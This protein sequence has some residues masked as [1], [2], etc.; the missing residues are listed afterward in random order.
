MRFFSQNDLE[1]IALQNKLQREAYAFIV[2][3][4]ENHRCYLQFELPFH[5]KKGTMYAGSMMV[6]WSF[7]KSLVYTIYRHNILEE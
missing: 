1:L 3:N 2:I 5:Y 4:Y 7:A 6:S